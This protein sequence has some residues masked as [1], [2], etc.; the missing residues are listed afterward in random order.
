[1][2]L[3]AKLGEIEGKKSSQIAGW[4]MRRAVTALGIGWQPEA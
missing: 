3:H 1:M 4:Y 2:L